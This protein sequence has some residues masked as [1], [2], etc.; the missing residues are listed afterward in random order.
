[1]KPHIESQVIFVGSIF[2]MKEIDERIN[3]MALYG[4]AMFPGFGL[5]ET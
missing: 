3:S 2:P 4:D 5:E 1:M